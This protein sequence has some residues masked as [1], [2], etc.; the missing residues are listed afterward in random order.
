MRTL[1]LYGGK[2]MRD[3]WKMAPATLIAGD[4]EFDAAVKAIRDGIGRRQ[5]TCFPMWRIFHKSPQGR[6]PILDWMHDLLEQAKRLPLDP[7][8][9]ADQNY[10]AKRAAPNIER[11]AQAESACGRPRLCRDAK[12]RAGPRIGEAADGPNGARRQSRATK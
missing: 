2:E 9:H 7:E 1:Q 10:T 11:K 3:L 6:K 8:S 5:N 4:A 12:A